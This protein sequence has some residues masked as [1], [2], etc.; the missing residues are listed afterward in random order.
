MAD[1]PGLDDD[2]AF[3]VEQTAAAERGTT[4]PERRVTVR[5][6]PL[7]LAGEPAFLM[8][9]STSLMKLSLRPRLPIRP[10]MILNS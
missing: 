1:H 5:S 4:S 2:A 7:P 3:G 8:A 9:R 10:S 6:T